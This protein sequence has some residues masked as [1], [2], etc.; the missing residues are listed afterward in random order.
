MVYILIREEQL[1]LNEAERLKRIYLNYVTDPAG[2]R[3]PFG[4][5]QYTFRDDSGY[6]A[7]D[8]FVGERSD[9][10]VVMRCWRFSQDVPSPSCL[11]DQ[12]GKRVCLP[13]LRPSP[14]ASS[15]PISVSGGKSPTASAA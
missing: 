9:G 6:R 2:K 11:R 13:L 14:I 5:T 15:A 10:P 12:R 4:L 7:E 1:N 8:L 3:G